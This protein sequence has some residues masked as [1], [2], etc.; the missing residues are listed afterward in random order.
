M[1][2]IAGRLRAEFGERIE[3]AEERLARFIQS[4]LRSRMISV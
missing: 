4:M 1:T 2:E 3:P